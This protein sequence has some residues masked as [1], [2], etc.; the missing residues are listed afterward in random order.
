M[1][2][3]FLDTLKSIGSHI[4]DVGV[5]IAKDVATKVIR[6]KLGVGRSGGAESGGAMSGGAMSGGR[7]QKHMM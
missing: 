6:S 2:G 7:M 1:G 3:G 5:P 4:L